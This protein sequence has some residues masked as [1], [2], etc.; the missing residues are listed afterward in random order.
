[1]RIITN[2]GAVGGGF[3]LIEVMVAVGIFAVI[4]AI[5]F[6]AMIQFIDVRDRVMAKHHQV[7]SLQKTFLFLAQ[8]LRF[9]SNR[10][11]KDEYGD[12]AD[13]TMVVDDDS[14]I[15]LTA[16]YPDLN[17]GGQNV[18]RRVRWV[19][20]DKTLLRLQSPVMDP[21]GDTRV[22]K[23]KLLENVR[24]VEIELS[25]VEDGRSSSSKRWDEKS[26]LPDMI[27]VTITLENKL[28]YER[29]FTMLGGDK[30]A[31]T[32]AAANSTEQAR[33]DADEGK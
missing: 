6:P 14:L 21:D 18:P 30:L 13:A 7:E 17:L 28:E 15:D 5:V 16:M 22:F 10:L 12:T 3:T 29:L 33:Q 31:A 11:G 26:R 24:K 27:R 2:K 32:A 8:D 23:Q 19:L 1:M 25:K 20:D 9:A 4:G